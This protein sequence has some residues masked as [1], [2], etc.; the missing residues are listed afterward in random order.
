MGHVA[1]VTPG[2]LVIREDVPRALVT[3]TPVSAVMSNQPAAS[4]TVKV[5]LALNN[6][7]QPK[8]TNYFVSNSF[9]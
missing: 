3:R 4:Q 9:F 2:A 7:L 6:I 5:A 8:L 1:T